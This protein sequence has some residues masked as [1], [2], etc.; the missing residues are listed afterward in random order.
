L[1]EVEDA[2]VAFRLEQQRRQ[3][4]QETVSSN[5]E[6]EELAQQL[7]RNGLTDYLTVLDAQ[8]SLYKSQEMLAVS[9]KKVTI[10]LI[11]LYK[12]LGGGWEPESAPVETPETMPPAMV[13]HSV[14][15]KTVLDVTP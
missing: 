13:S 9:E 1:R 4:L 6:A 7:Y 12:A 10:N 8:R 3:F 11:V 15:Q 14:S 5:Q 2:I